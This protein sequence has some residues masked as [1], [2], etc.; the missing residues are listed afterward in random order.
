VKRREFI[1]LL[2]GLYDRPRI[3]RL[4]GK[5]AAIDYRANCRAQM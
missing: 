5:P 3:N 1:A 4:T 2:R